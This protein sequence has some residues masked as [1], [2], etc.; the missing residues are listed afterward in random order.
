MLFHALSGLTD[1]AVSNDLTAEEIRHRLSLHARHLAG[2]TT[3]VEYARWTEA[4]APKIIV[5]PESLTIHITSDHLSKLTAAPF[6]NVAELNT[7]PV[8]IPTKVTQ[9]GNKVILT[10][11]VSFKPQRGKCEIIDGETGKAITTRKTAPNP[12]LIQTI[13]QAEFWRTELIKHPD[14]S[15]QDITEQHGIKP[16]YVRRL[17]NA[18]YLAPAIK[19]AIF[20]GTQPAHLQVQDLLMPR[21]LDW[22]QQLS[23]LGFE[24]EKPA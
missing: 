20:Q 24:N 13:A 17:L 12:A 3:P 5:G 11:S 2:L 21:S 23:D 15:L 10:A 8:P 6:S 16:A 22:K 9:E 1:L 18:A 19:R 4:L 7:L 14:K